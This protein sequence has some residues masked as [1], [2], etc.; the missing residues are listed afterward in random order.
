[1]EAQTL[2]LEDLF[3]RLNCAHIPNFQSGQEWLLPERCSPVVN[4]VLAQR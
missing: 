1:M 3:M 2:E 4:A